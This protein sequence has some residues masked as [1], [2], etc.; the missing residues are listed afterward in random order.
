MARTNGNGWK[1]KTDVWQGYVKA[2]LEDI[3]NEQKDLKAALK[4]HRDDTDKRFDK[5]ETRVHAL[6]KFKDN[7]KMAVAT[8]A[9]SVTI[10]FNLVV[11]FL[12]DVLVGLKG[13]GA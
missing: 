8:I 12:K 6:E 9:T 7:V 1:S 10:L 5:L 13:K 4:D 2:K 11:L 3:Y